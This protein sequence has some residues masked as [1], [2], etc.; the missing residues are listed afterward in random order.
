MAL[1]PYI[2]L[3]RAMNTSTSTGTGNMVLGA[4]VDG[5]VT[6]D[7]APIADDAYYLI[8]YCIEGI[9][10]ACLGEV[11]IGIGTIV[12]GELVRGSSQYNIV[13]EVFASGAQTFSA[14][15]KLVYLRTQPATGNGVNHT[16]ALMGFRYVLGFNAVS[17]SA[18]TTNATPTVMEGAAVDVSATT[19]IIANTF[20][21]SLIASTRASSF[22]LFVIADDG[23]DAKSWTFDFLV[24]H[25]GTASVIGSPTPTVITA[26]AGA[27]S[28]TLGVSASGDEIVLS[29]TGEAAKNITWNGTGRFVT[30]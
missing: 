3:E 1:A 25:N 20:D 17:V 24:R 29:A 13:A 21:L 4:A 26:S 6:L 27:A 15:T 19:P 11:E 5:Y 30:V 28:W 22:Q 10:G 7:Q 2:A 16:A 8:P 12:A 18:S 9:D 23:T 14:G